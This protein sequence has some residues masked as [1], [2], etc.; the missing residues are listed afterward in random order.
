MIHRDVKP[1]NFLIDAQGHLKLA[2]FGLATDFHWAERKSD[3]EE[4]HTRKFSVVS[5]N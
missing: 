4:E 2:D 3:M 5:S 1:D